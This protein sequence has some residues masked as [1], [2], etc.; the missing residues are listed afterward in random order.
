[1][2]GGSKN[3]ENFDEPL[4]LVGGENNAYTS[5]DVTNYYITVPTVN[6]ETAFWLESDRMLSLSFEDNVLE[7]QRKV[8]IEEFKQRYLNQPYGDVWL[9]LRPLAYE[10]H[11]YR[12]ATIGKDIEHI[13]EATM[14]DVKAFFNK[15]Y[16]PNNAVLVVGGNVTVEQVK[17]LAEKW[18]GPIPKGEPYIRKL[19]QETQQTSPKFLEVEADVPLNALYKAYH[20]G[21]RMDDDFYAI[22]LLSDVLGRGESSR[23]YQALVKNKQIFTS[24][25]AS[26]TGSFES[27]LFLITGFLAKGVSYE[28]AE[29][30]LDKLI[31]QIQTELVEEE[32]LFKVK[33]QAESSILFSQIELL[34]RCSSLAYGALLGNLN[35][36]NEES[37]WIQ[38]VEREDILKAAQKVLRKDNCSTL[39]YKSKN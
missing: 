9:K 16:L 24:I 27:G 5:P 12:W 7:V 30:E 8:V 39:H 18:F 14:Q 11:P 10:K 17:E 34:E 38:K 31:Q 6:L 3:I 25:N 33:N 37:S 20:M 26:L 2:F 28:D 1:M 22:D 29:K 23:L 32:E 35:L 36:V 13:E 15:F 19:Q 21:A 4:Q